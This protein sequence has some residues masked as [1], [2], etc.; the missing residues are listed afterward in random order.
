MEPDGATAK[1]RHG[2]ETA[3]GRSV[4]GTVLD[5]V[6]A[7]IPDDGDGMTAIVGGIQTMACRPDSMCGTSSLHFDG[8]VQR[9]AATGSVDDGNDAAIRR[10]VPVG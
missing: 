4:C 9:A 5:S 8:R 7:F 10:R 6:F 2:T 1:T 3:S